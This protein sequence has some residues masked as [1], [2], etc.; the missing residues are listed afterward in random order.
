MVEIFTS[1]FAPSFEFPICSLKPARSAAAH[2]RAEGMNLGAV[3][4]AEICRY[5]LPPRFTAA[6]AHHASGRWY[7]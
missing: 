3:L 5:F 2:T 7:G 6:L 4:D 1:N